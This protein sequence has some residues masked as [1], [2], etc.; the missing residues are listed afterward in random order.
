[1]GRIVLKTFVELPNNNGYNIGTK[2]H[3]NYLSFID[4]VNQMYNYDRT[5]LLMSR[6]SYL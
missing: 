4:K 1:M 6:A 5:P 2:E 3:K